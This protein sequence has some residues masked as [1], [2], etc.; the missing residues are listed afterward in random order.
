MLATNNK[1]YNPITRQSE[2]QQLPEFG[3][4]VA[5]VFRCKWIVKVTRIIQQYWIWTTNLIKAQTMPQIKPPP[6]YTDRII[7]TTEKIY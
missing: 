1:Q 6:Q 2:I 5:T 7:N 3:R 4:C